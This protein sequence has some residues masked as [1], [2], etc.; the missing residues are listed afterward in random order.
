MKIKGIE[1]VE[2]VKKK[3]SQCLRMLGNVPERATQFK[4]KAILNQHVY[5]TPSSPGPFFPKHFK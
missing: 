1:I 3:W 5:F 2:A 4:S